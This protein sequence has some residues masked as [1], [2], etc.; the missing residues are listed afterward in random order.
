M[1]LLRNTEKILHVP[2]VKA[3][4]TVRSIS[5]FM[6]QH[7]GFLMLVMT[8]KR[9][10]LSQQELPSPQ[11]PALCLPPTRAQ[12]WVLTPWGR[13]ARGP[14]W[15]CWWESAKKTREQNNTTWAN[16]VLVQLVASRPNKQNFVLSTL[17][18]FPRWPAEVSN[19]L[20][21]SVT[22]IG[23]NI[24]SSSSA[25]FNVWLGEQVIRLSWDCKQKG[26]E[27]RC[28]TAYCTIPV[29]YAAPSAWGQPALSNR[30][31]SSLS[32]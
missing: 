1:E 3:S 19:F 4:N 10:A 31:P 15:L 5:T 18:H 17:L 30:P 7:P 32:R 20:R 8:A 13:A 12:P 25:C 6:W 22:S 29:R 2:P 26:E 16:I 27:Q 14:D 11:C 9:T 28:N 21:L 24:F 23:N